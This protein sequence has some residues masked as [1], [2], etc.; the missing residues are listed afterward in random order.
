MNEFLITSILSAIIVSFSQVSY[1]I[2]ESDGRIQPTL[3]FSNPSSSDITLQVE[4]T[5]NTAIGKLV[6]ND[7]RDI[8]YKPT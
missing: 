1:N 7:I 8:S 6:C 3:L 2:N 4:D 5:S